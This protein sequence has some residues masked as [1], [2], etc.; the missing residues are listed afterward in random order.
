MYFITC[1]AAALCA[2]LCAAVLVV[3]QAAITAAAAK[4]FPCTLR[5]RDTFYTP[6]LEGYTDYPFLNEQQVVVSF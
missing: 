3:A 4:Q 6:G 5:R 1:A 2:C